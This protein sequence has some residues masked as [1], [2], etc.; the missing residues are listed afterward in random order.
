MNIRALQAFNAVLTEGSVSGAAR[1]MNL[2]QPAVSRLIALLEAELRLTLFKR[3]RQR[4]FLTEEGAAF[5]REARR[6]LAGL[7]DIPRIADEIRAHRFKRLR[8]VTMPRAALSVVA[9]AVARFTQVYPDVEVSLDM[10]SHRDLETW[11]NGREY[12][13]GFGNVPIT[14]RSAVDMPLVRSV[15]EVLMPRD[16][17]FTDREVVRMEDLA[18]EPLVQQFP[19]MLLRRQTDALFDAHD[20]RVGRDVLTGSSLLAQHLVAGGAGLTIIDRL[21]VLSMNPTVVTSRPL[22]PTRWVN[23]GVIRHRDEDPDPMARDMIQLLRDRVAECAVPGSI[24]VID[25]G[26]S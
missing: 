15:L 10:R 5:V 18:K 24:E 9:P 7:R 13:L 12:D 19:G 2:S 4:L 14:H 26:A 20:I 21:S 23:F 1:V 17:P 11:I 16:H 25:G 3:E 8:V 22:H 6:I